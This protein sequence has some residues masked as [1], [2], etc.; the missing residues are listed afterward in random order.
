GQ[1]LVVALEGARRLGSPMDGVLQ[2][3]SSD[4]FVLQQQDDSPGLDPLLVF[5]AP[6]DGRYVVRAF[7]FPATATA[8]ISFAGGEDY[9]YRLTLTTEG[10]LDFTLPLAIGREQLGL[11]EGFGWNLPFESRRLRVD[12]TGRPDRARAWHP[13][14]AGDWE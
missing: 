12:R 7:A 10:A 13:L 9:I 8:S 2:I 6:E 1:V 3:V 14:L 4:G 11:V 5:E